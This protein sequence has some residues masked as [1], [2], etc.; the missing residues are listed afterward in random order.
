[1]S[2]VEKSI[3][4]VINKINA[5]TSRSLFGGGEMV[6]PLEQAQL[7]QRTRVKFLAP[8]QQVTSVTLATGNLLP[9]APQTPAPQ[10]HTHMQ[11]HT[12]LTL[13]KNDKNKTSSLR[14]TSFGSWGPCLILSG[15]SAL[16]RKMWQWLV[17]PASLG[18]TCTDS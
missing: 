10:A 6:Q 15:L 8:R 14:S 3:P 9:L 7:L 11:T 5:K 12:C 1:M 2:L 18:C 16:G 13:V 17:G 4:L